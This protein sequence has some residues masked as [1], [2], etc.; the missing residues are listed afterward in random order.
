M[1]AAMSIIDRD[2]IMCQGEIEKVLP[3]SFYFLTIRGTVPV[4]AVENCSRVSQGAVGA[5]LAATAPAASPGSSWLSRAAQRAFTIE[6]AG[7]ATP[8]MDARPRRLM[9]A[10]DSGGRLPGVG[11]TGPVITVH[12]IRGSRYRSSIARSV[13]DG[14]GRPGRSPGVLRIEGEGSRRSDHGHSPRAESGAVGVGL[15]QEDAVN[16]Q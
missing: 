13:R 16:N 9:R 10:L 3:S 7:I 2:E 11:F 15:G 4:V 8:G 14:S 12:C 1:V 5:F 6:R